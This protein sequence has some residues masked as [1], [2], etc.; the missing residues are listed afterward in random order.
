MRNAALACAPIMA[1]GV[2]GFAAA[3]ALDH[4]IDIRA[5]FMPRTRRLHHRSRPVAVRPVTV[6][7]LTRSF[8]NGRMGCLADPGWSLTSEQVR[9]AGVR[10]LGALHLDDPR[11]AEGQVL[12][13]GGLTMPDARQHDVVF[14]CDMSNNVYAFDANDFALLWKRNVGRPVSITVKWDMWLVNPFWGILSTP[15]IN[16]ATRTLYCVSTSSEDGTME[17]AVYALHSLDLVNGADQAPPLVLNGASYQPPGEVPRQT[18]GAVARKQ[19]PALTLLSVEG[20]ATVFIPFGSFLESATTNLGW[21][22][23]VDVSNPQRPAVAASWTTGSGQYPGAGI[24]QA[25]QGLS[26]DENNNLHGMTG[27]GGFDPPSGNFGNCFFR[28]AYSPAGNGNPAAL[29]CTDWWSP[30]SDAGRAGDDPTLATPD[31]DPPDDMAAVPVNAANATSNAHIVGDEDLGSG[32]A[33]LLPGSFTGFAKDVIVGGG[34]D[35][36]YYVLDSARL[37]QT[38]RV[39]FA[40]AAIARN[41]AKLLSP[42]WAVTYCG[43]GLDLAPT[44]LDALP[45]AFGGYTR[46]IHGSPVGYKSPDHGIMLFVQGENGPVQAAS[47]NPDFT[48]GWVAA[49]REVASQGMLPPGGM[50]G[51]MLVLTCQREGDNTGVLWALMPWYGNA[52]KAPPTA[53]RMVAYGANWV[54]EAGPTLIKLWD[55]ADWGIDYKHAKFNLLTPF[56]NRLFVPSYDGRILVIG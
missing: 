2:F 3:A 15:V 55:S 11:G 41:W 9:A 26:V 22:V 49:G 14:V 13:V 7:V 28:L 54:D 23:A 21:V 30:Y 40:P 6:D 18:L 1:A 42:P 20:H 46:H 47:L 16:L 53:G 24:W 12:A 17:A 25:G 37:G 38:Q 52:N 29:R 32:G 19:R 51:G 50:P 35:G 5:L 27:N 48:L 39:D 44:Q 45:S 56:G 31:S 36:I 4:A 10:V 33:L 8:G 43:L 34:K